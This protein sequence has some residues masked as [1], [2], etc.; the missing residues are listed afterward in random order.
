MPVTA[1]S[2]SSP[3]C[4]VAPVLARVGFTS[5]DGASI[6]VTSGCPAA[7]ISPAK[8]SVGDDAVDGNGFQVADACRTDA[9]GGELC[10]MALL[11]RGFAVTAFCEARCLEAMS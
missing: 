11:D 3:T 2:A 8:R 6:T 7:A 1:T 5:N 10:P 4:I 9:L